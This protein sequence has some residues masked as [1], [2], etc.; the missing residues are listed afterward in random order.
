MANPPIATV[1][2]LNY[3]CLGWIFHSPPPNFAFICRAMFDATDI[4]FFMRLFF[5]TF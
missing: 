5:S 1:L 4:A 3:L 2:F